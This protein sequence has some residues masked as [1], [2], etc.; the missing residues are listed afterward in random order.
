[1]IYHSLIYDVAGPVATITLNR[2]ESLNALT[3]ELDAELHEALDQA[4][5]DP[6]VRAIILTGSGRAFCAGFDVKDNRAAPEG[7]NIA[8]YILERYNRDTVTTQNL[9]HVWR[10]SKPVIAAVNGWAMGGGFW[11]QLVCDITLASDRAVFAQPEVRHT[12]NST[13]FLAALCGW[14]VAHR[15]ALTGDHLDAAEAL[16]VGLVNEVVP[17]EELLPTARRLAER[18]AKVP[19]ASVRMSKAITAQGLLAAGVY[20]GL[21]VNDALSGLAHSS[22]GPSRERLDT[23]REEQGLRGFLDARDGQFLPEPFGPKSSRKEEGE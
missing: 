4:D 3:P 1:V 18:I 15:F 13:F 23:I 19:E 6:A 16:R 17:H 5:A 7:I 12:S 2:P 10:L 11:Y 14:K 20:S 9:L 21:M 22:Y 8:D